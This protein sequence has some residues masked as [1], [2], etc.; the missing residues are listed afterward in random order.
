MLLADVNADKDKYIEREFMIELSDLMY[1]YGVNRVDAYWGV[2]VPCSRCGESS[3]KEVNGEHITM[4]SLDDPR[5]EPDIK[6]NEALEMLGKCVDKVPDGEIKI[7][8][9]GEDEDE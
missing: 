6:K 1:R 5:L 9:R 7:E 8:M 2:P 4:L 3:H